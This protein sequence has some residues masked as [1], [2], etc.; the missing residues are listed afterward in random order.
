MSML[1]ITSSILA[2]FPPSFS[3]LSREEEAGRPVALQGDGPKD[4]EFV[5][6][7]LPLPLFISLLSVEGSSGPIF[8]AKFAGGSGWG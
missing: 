5:G 1:H 2:P 7:E 3:T 6:E 8:W 4:L